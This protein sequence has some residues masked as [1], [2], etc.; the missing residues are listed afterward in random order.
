MIT[1]ITG[2]PGTGKTALL[3]EMIMEELK[4]GRKVFTKGIPKLLLNVFKAGD[5]HTW[6]DGTWLKIDHYNP[7]LTK[8]RG[9]E[10]EWFPAGC[11]QTCPFLSTCPR[12]GQEAFKPDAGALLIVDEAHTDFP[13]RSSGKAVPPHVEALLVH[14][15]QGLDIWFL[16]QKPSF[17]DPFIRG[18]ASRHIHLGLNP[19]SFTGSRNKYEWV[20]FQE[21]VNRQSKA[22]AHKVSYKPA[23]HVFPLYASATIHTKL[24]QRIPTIMKVFIT[25]LLSGVVLAGYAVNRV[26]SKGDPQP[27][28]SSHSS[29]AAVLAVA[30]AIVPALVAGIPP[31]ANNLDVSLGKMGVA[32]SKEVQRPIVMLK[33]A[34]GYYGDDVT[35]AAH[36]TSEELANQ[37]RNSRVLSANEG[38]RVYA[39]TVSVSELNANIPVTF[40]KPDRAGAYGS[41]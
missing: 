4:Q 19:F 31:T 15:H 28:T 1:I 2:V 24:D 18:A 22:L 41:F 32:V 29:T 21:T 20:E 3:L 30:P 25:L 7:A 17:L 38:S 8:A 23:P 35:V 33:L 13:Q 6:Q 34:A 37:S 36:Y 12:V 26:K 10:G 14:R 5:L 9:V 11:K 27:F 40:V 39:A 16:S